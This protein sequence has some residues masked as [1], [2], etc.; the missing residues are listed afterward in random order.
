MSGSPRAIGTL[1][2]AVS[3]LGFS[4]LPLFGV[5]A[6][7]AGAN[8]TTLLGVRFTVAA[9]VLWV[10][11]LWK[12][13]PLP[14]RRTAVQLLLMGMVG[15][16]TMSLL[17]L[18]SVASDRLSPSLAALLLYTYPAIVALLA[19][20][21][22]G[23][24]MG[25]RQLAAL[26]VTWGG[27]VLVLLAPDKASVFTPTGAMLALGAAL[28]YA[29]Y[30]VLGSRVSRRTSPLITTTYVS[31]AAT[32][33]FLAFGAA[34][35]GLVPVAP[36]GWLAMAGAGLVATVL[37]V[38]LFFSGMERLGPAGASMV[39]TLEPVGTAALSALLFGDQLG[40]YQIVGGLF[41]L[42]GVVWLQTAKE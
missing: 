17:Y 42:A 34:T 16:T 40:M 1:L 7:E 8:V 22:D 35:G 28:V 24:R 23:Q 6:Y 31:T 11:V 25:A 38:M 41:V 12:R 33:L 14:D 21:L 20:W 39:S 4:T 10:Y 26:P 18:S 9:I 3:A 13:P 2:T 30:I 15:Y 19:W 36:A 32:V 37:A 27:V 5:V 29:A